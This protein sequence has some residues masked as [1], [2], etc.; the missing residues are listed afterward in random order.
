MPFNEININLNQPDLGTLEGQYFDEFILGYERNIRDQFKV[1][2][3]GTYRRLGQVLKPGINPETN[4]WM[5]GNPGSGSLDFLPQL[6]R[7][8]QAVEISLQKSASRRFN[9]LTSYVLSRNSGNYTGLFNL[10]TGAA[11]ANLGS[12]PLLPLQ[13]P[14]GNGLL[15]ND[16]THVF[17]FSG[18]YRTDIG[19]TAGASFFWQSGTPITE[20][21]IF[22][23]IFPVFYFL[24]KRGSTGRT[25]AITDL[26]VRLKYDLGRLASRGFNASLIL[27]GLHLLNQ[28]NVTEVDQVHFQG[29]DE[30]DN[31]IAPNPNY[32]NP[33]GFEPARTVR[34]GMEV[35]F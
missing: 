10:E 6:E 28:R 20:L 1:A 35:K 16:R 4:V 30:N 9:F 8:Y 19:L 21:G 33:V 13:I 29:V 7:D 25:S 11:I 23:S 12:V 26:S 22:P 24:S 31:P 27:D 15:P 34:L 14:N 2:L 5:V 3:R 17:K 18:S 32:L